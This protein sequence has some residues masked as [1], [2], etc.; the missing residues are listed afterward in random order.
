MLLKVIRIQH[1]DKPYLYHTL[2]SVAQGLMPESIKSLR[3]ILY[4]YYHLLQELPGR[5]PQMRLSPV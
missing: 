3:E 4:Y 2:L 1:P 5:P